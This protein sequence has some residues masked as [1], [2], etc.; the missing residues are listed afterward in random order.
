MFTSL[1]AEKMM[2]V[3]EGAALLKAGK[4]AEAAKAF[5]LITTKQKDNLQALFL[6]GVCH[7]KLQQY[8]QAEAMFRNI[9]SLRSNYAQAHYY[10]GLVLELQNKPQEAKQAFQKALSCKPDFAEAKKKL[11]QYASHHD[12]RVQSFLRPPQP[13]TLGQSILPQGGLIIQGHRRMC[14]FSFTYLI[15]LMLY[16]L[17]AMSLLVAP[18]DETHLILFFWGTILLMALFIRSRSTK[19][20]IFEN[21]IDYSSGILFRQS[22]SLWMYQIEQTS[23]SRS[24]FNLFTGD[25]RIQ[26]QSSDIGQVT[27]GGIGYYILYAL[28]AII[29]LVTL[30][31]LSFRFI[32]H[33]QDQLVNSPMTI[34][35]T[36]LGNYHK[37]KST[38]EWI[39]DR[40]LGQRREYKQHLMR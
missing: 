10:L 21:R 27:N 20:S 19:Y 9:I 28:N 6:L 8:Q 18:Q 13:S 2:T 16:G 35:I 38:W 24:F 5:R 1:F 26:I 23:L 32:L 39:R 25:A 22:H 40:S 4:I 12:S 29:E 31:L 34:N 3:E 33:R 14:S 15:M 37:M 7:H 30:G 17:G 11:E 36:G